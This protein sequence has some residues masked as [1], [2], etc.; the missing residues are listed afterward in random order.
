MTSK[1]GVKEK[2]AVRANLLSLIELTVKEIDGAE[3]FIIPDGLVVRGVAPTDILVKAIVKNEDV[4]VEAIL[5]DVAVKEREK[6]E[7]AKERE[8]KKAKDAEKREKAKAE[9]E[10]K[11]NDPD[12][13]RRKGE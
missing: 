1:F 13:P 5:L 10:A 8:A 4:D 11:I 7:K 2:Q 6:K 9:R 12:R 3:T